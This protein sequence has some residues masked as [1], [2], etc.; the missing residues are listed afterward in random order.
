MFFLLGAVF[1]F[2]RVIINKDVTSHRHSVTG[3]NRAAGE[4]PDMEREIVLTG[5]PAILKEH[6]LE[7]PQAREQEPSEF[8][9]YLPSWE[10]D[11]ISNATAQSRYR[12]VGGFFPGVTGGE[13]KD[14]M[15]VVERGVSWRDPSLKITP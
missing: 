2:V 15:M 10:F 7:S 4:T 1:F 8:H 5:C 14:P 13:L 12:R 9:L 6:Q 3:A 11:C